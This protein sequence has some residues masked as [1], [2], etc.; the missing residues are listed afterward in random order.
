MS[1]L[2]RSTCLMQDSLALQLRRKVR[3]TDTITHKRTISRR[4]RKTGK[5][6]L[7]SGPAS[8]QPLPTSCWK[9]YPSKWCGN[10]S[11][12]WTSPHQKKQKRGDTQPHPK[13]E[14]EDNPTDGPP[15]RKEETKQHHPTEDRR[16]AP[17]PKGG[18]GRQLHQ[19]GGRKNSNTTP[20]RE[21]ETKQHHP[22]RR[23]KKVCV[24]WTW[25]D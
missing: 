15:R 18:E 20:K 16:N 5:W 10:C 25:V 3:A 11:Y 22:T 12:S 8:C 21:Q 1:V 6:E 2:G 13:E 19:T 17:L 9:C 4:Q 24:S 7:V 14:K 23:G